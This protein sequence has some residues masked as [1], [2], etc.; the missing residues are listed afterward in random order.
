MFGRREQSNR[1]I[2]LCTVALLAAPLC[3]GSPQV[4]ASY[5]DGERYAFMG[6]KAANEVYVID[7]HSRARVHTLHLSKAPD[8]VAASNALRALV[9]GHAAD[10]ML[11]LVDLASESLEQYEYPLTLKP[12]TVL[13]S[14]IGE[15]VAILDRENARLQVHALR[16]RE[17]LLTVDD[18]RTESELTFSPDGSTVYWVDQAA[19]TLQ[20]ADLWSK[21]RSLRLTTD[22]SALTAMSRSID[23]TR[24]FISDADNATVHV[25]NLQE[26]SLLRASPVGPAPGRPWGTADGRFMLVPNGNGTVTA[27]SVLTSESLYT[28]D[29]VANPVSIN[30]GWIDTTAAVVGAD[31]K[32]AFINIADG[33]ELA[34]VDLGNSPQEGI[35]T[36]DSRTLAVP[37]PGA[38]VFFDMQKRAQISAIRG[39]PNDIGPAA[40]AISNNLCH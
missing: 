14:P 18:V 5:D 36:S 6:S 35:V 26:F 32:L 27:L 13:V 22:D 8:S 40:L 21:R 10:S 37:L 16:R 24:G 31:G 25:V 34:R 20:S 2:G 29:A 38:L 3:C 11:T 15:T 23:G 28:V 30:P 9:I 17:V 19:G 33:K 7:L 12:Q 39:L 1:S 4:F